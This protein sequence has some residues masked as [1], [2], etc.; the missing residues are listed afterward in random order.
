M[1]NQTKSEKQAIDAK[2]AKVKEVV[3]GVSNND[4]IL[5]LNF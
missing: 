3:R 1:S 4:I 5:G 2:I